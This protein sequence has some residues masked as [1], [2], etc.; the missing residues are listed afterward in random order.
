MAVPDAA[1]NNSAIRNWE[2][3]WLSLVRASSAPSDS[4]PPPPDNDMGMTSCAPD[5]RRQWRSGARVGLLRC[6]YTGWVRRFG[7]GRWDG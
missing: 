2:R 3:P 5:P 1:H 6:S 4:A 7:G